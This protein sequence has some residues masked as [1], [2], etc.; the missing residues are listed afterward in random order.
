MIGGRLVGQGTYGCVFQPPLLCKHKD[1]SKTKVGK[2]TYKGDS[3]REIS[4]YKVL[5]KIEEWQQYFILSAPS[6]SCSP[7][8]VENQVEPDLSKCEFLMEADNNLQI[9]QLLMPYGGKDL[10]THSLIN[11]KKIPFFILCR[12][13]LEAGA[14]MILHGIVHYDIHS[15]NILIDSSG[16]A[17]IIDF[18][19]C[20]NSNS[21]T[22]DSIEQRWKVLGPE[23]AAE[24]P[25]VTFLTA[26]ERPY[27][28]SFEDALHD[29]MPKKRILYTIEKVL[30]IPVE[31]QIRSL[32]KFFKSSS[33]FQTHNETTLV[34][35]W[36]IY[37]PGYDSWSIGILLLEYLQRYLYSYE[38]VESS[39][40]KLK[41]FIIMEILEKMT[42]TNPKERIDCVE[43]LSM[44]DPFNNIYQKYGVKWVEQRRKQRS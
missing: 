31:V 42:S 26:M 16:T 7:R 34:K 13:L 38:F 5:H 15:R 12:Q 21:I 22:L 6:D 33:I 11:T 40:W 35:L 3:Q 9:E 41:R 24:P 29:V 43:A 32:E 20:F 8:I 2:I 4:A 37:Y 23:Y 25:E 10:Y 18:G 39:E 19:Q 1:V 14:L 36:K 44:Y 17:R 28:Y 27:Y 30:G